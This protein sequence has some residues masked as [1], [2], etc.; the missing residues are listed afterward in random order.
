MNKLNFQL[1]QNILLT[2]NNS[3]ILSQLNYCLLACDYEC[4]EASKYVYN[5]IIIF[6]Y[7]K[8]ASMFAIYYPNGCILNNI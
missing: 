8:V 3:L 1:P 7:Y 6:L 2:I 5:K 4:Y